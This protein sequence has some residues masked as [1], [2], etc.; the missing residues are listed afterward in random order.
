MMRKL[1][2][3]LGIK[4]HIFT[5]ISCFILCPFLSITHYYFVLLSYFFFPLFIFIVKCI[6]IVM[7]RVYCWQWGHA[8]SKLQY[9]DKRD[10]N[11]VKWAN[12]VLKETTQILNQLH[13]QESWILRDDKTEA[14]H[15]RSHEFKMAFV[16]YCLFFIWNSLNNSVSAATRWLITLEMIKWTINN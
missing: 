8:K 10:G 16:N 12:T 7:A 5:V 3:K 2:V 1:Q 6:V 4:L 14:W 15:N 13:H 11:K 9:A